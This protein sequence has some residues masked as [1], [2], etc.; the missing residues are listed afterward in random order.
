MIHQNFTKIG[1]I[2]G[3]GTLPQKLADACKA[4]NIDV[5]VVGF[6]GQSDEAFLASQDHIK[7]KLGQVGK[8]M[9]AFK[10]RG[11][12]DLVLIGSIERP[13]FSELIPDLKAA[14]FLA[15]T[16]F[17]AMGDSDLLSALRRFLEDEGF[18]VHGVQTFMP[19]LLTPEGTLTKTEPSKD[20]LIDIKRG[21]E[22]LKEMSALDIGQA[23]VVQEGLV[24]GVEAIEGT[25]ALIKR[26]GDLKRK[27]RKGVLVKLCK[28]QQDVSLDLPTIGVKTIKAVKE[29]GFGGI[30]VH[31]GKS[32]ISDK[33]ELVSFANAHHLYIVGIDPKTY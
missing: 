1:I 24:L 29:A 12:R 20:D 17:K 16:G 13:S 5:F 14:K 32:L 28:E 18:K 30:I 3:G 15:S 6:E 7:A 22:V 33:E 10:K 31:A 8:I 19:E 26:C 9:K 2:A 27:G 4:L 23:I 11:I 21:V 25:S